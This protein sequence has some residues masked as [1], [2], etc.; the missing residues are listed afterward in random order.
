VTKKSTS[1]GFACAVG[2]IAGALLLL[3][4]LASQASAAGN[5]FSTEPAALPPSTPWFVSL[6]LHVLIIAGIVG[7]AVTVLVAMFKSP[8]R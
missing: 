1:G 3:M 6:A 7:L 5:P 2:I 8:F 4:F